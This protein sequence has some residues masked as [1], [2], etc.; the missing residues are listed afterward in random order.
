MSC[1]CM[2]FSEEKTTLLFIK[3]FILRTI[4][5]KN[6]YYSQEILTYVIV[7]FITNTTK[8]CHLAEKY[9]NLLTI[10]GPKKT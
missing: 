6:K 5:K 8:T 9:L 2:E 7:N 1:N 4:S 3:I 10:D